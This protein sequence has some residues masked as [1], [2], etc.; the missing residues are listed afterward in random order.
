MVPEMQES[1]SESILVRC[2]RDPNE[3]D[4]NRLSKTKNERL[5]FLIYHIDIKWDNKITENQSENIQ[6]ENSL[7]E[8]IQKT[9]KQTN[10]KN[11]F[12]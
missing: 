3:I 10:G 7:K 5:S 11:Q 4:N 8:D 6:K 12:R 9:L 1:A 2:Q